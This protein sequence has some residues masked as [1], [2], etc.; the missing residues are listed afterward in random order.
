VEISCSL[1]LVRD[2]ANITNFEKNP[3]AETKPILAELRSHKL[4]VQEQTS[5]VG[6][7][8]EFTIT[9]ITMNV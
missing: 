8:G 6:V 9:H 2:Q 3:N 7:E 4:S 5:Y 1:I